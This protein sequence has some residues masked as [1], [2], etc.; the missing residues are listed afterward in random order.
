MAALNFWNMFYLH[1]YKIIFS[2][3]FFLV[4]G[5]SVFAQAPKIKKGRILERNLPN[6]DYRK[7]HYGFYL[8]ATFTRLNGEHSQSFVD[9][10]SKNGL[11]TRA[12]PKYSPGFTL[13]F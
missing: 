8:G 12:N 9:S 7:M 4:L 1:R 10:L 6:Y 11:V 2:F 5:T 3:L 13:G